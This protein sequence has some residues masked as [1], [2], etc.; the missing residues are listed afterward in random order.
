MKY[1]KSLLAFAMVALM[2]SS[3]LAAD[4][5][6]GE[7]TLITLKV[8]ESVDVTGPSKEDGRW[9]SISASSS[10]NASSYESD[11]ANALAIATPAFVPAQEDRTIMSKGSCNGATIRF[12]GVAVGTTKFYIYGAKD[13]GTTPTE[14]PDRPYGGQTTWSNS[15][16]NPKSFEITVTDPEQPST[17]EDVRLTPDGDAVVKTAPDS[18]AT[19]EWSMKLIP[20]DTTVV[21][22]QFDATTR[23]VTIAPLAVGSA[24]VRILKGTT[25]VID[26][27]VTVANPSAK[28]LI[29]SSVTPTGTDDQPIYSFTDT[30]ATGSL[31]IPA[32]YKATA[33]ILVIGGGAKGSDATSSRGASGGY[34]GQGSDNNNVALAANDYTITI[35][36]GQ[37]A[38]TIAGASTFTGGS[39]SYTGAAAASNRAGFNSTSDITGERVSYGQTGATGARNTSAQA[40][41]A[42]TG[43]GGQGGYGTSTY[44][45]GGNG[46]SGIVIVKILSFE[47]LPKPVVNNAIAGTLTY[48]Q[49]LSTIS[50]I[51][52]TMTNAQ[53][54]AVSGSFAWACDTTVK[55]TV[56]E[57]GVA[58]YDATFTPS[59]SDYWTPVNVK[60]AVTVNKKELTA[61]AKSF[62]VERGRSV[63]AEDYEVTY[64][65]WVNGES[66]ATAAGF[67]PATATSEYSPTTTYP[68]N[69]QLDIIV[70]G[71]EADN[72]AF[73]Y[74]NGK[75]TVL[76]PSK[77]DVQLTDVD[78]SSGVNGKNI[79]DAE[80]RPVV[81]LG[82]K[83]Y[84]FDANANN[85]E[86][87]LMSAGKYAVDESYQLEGGEISKFLLGEFAGSSFAEAFLPDGAWFTGG[88]FAISEDGTTVTFDGGTL[89]YNDDD[90]TVPFAGTIELV[91]DL[92]IYVEDELT[93]KFPA[94]VTFTG[95]GKIIKTGAGTLDFDSEVTDVSAEGYEGE[96][97]GEVHQPTVS[98]T[99]TPAA[100]VDPAR[101]AVVQYKQAGA[102]AWTA[103]APSFSEV[104]DTTV[105]YQ[106]LVAGIRKAYGTYAVKITQKTPETEPISIVM[107]ESQ[108]VS[109]Q[110]VSSDEEWTVK[111]TGADG[112]VT[113]DP[114]AYTGKLFQPT[115]TAGSAKGTATVTIES[116]NV[117]Y[118]YTVTVTASFDENKVNLAYAGEGLADEVTTYWWYYDSA[119]SVKPRHF[120][121]SL[122]GTGVSVDTTV[123]KAVEPYRATVITA[124]NASGTPTVTV[125]RASTLENGELGGTPQVSGTYPIS[126]TAKRVVYVNQ[127]K[128][129]YCWAVKETNWT[130]GEWTAVSA[131]E[132]TVAIGEDYEGGTA[133]DTM[134]PFVGK[135]AGQTYLTVSNVKTLTDMTYNWN[136]T[137]ATTE[138]KAVTKGEVKQGSSYKLW[139]E[140]RDTPKADGQI[141]GSDTIKVGEKL[142]TIDI[143]G[144][145]V[146]AAGEEVEGT[147]AWV[148]GETIVPEPT[149][150]QTFQATFTPDGDF[151]DEV[152]V[153]VTVMVIPSTKPT[154]TIYIEQGDY[155]EDVQTNGVSVTGELE[156][157]AEATAVTLT[158]EADL[159][160]LTIPVFKVV[161]GNVTNVTTKVAT[162]TIADGDTLEFFAEEAEWTDPTVTDDDIK[163]ALLESI[164][165]NDP[166]THEAAVKKVNDV[167]GT[168]ANQVSA[169]ALA[170]YI[171]DRNSQS[172]DIADCDYVAASVKLDTDNLITEETEVEI[173]ELVKAEGDG[174]T[175]E[176]YIEDDL[177]EVEAIKDMVEA[178][179]DLTDWVT[180]EHKLEVEAE[181]NKDTSMVKITP[182]D[183][184]DKAF[185]RVVIPKDPGVSSNA[186][187]KKGSGADG[188]SEVMSQIV[189]MAKRTT[190]VAAGKKV[191]EA[192]SVT[193]TDTDGSDIPLQKVVSLDAV[194][195]D[196]L[197][198]A[199]N[200][201]TE[202]YDCWKLSETKVW[203]AQSTV[204]VSGGVVTSGTPSADRTFALGEVIWLERQDATVPLHLYGGVDEDAE[205]PAINKGMNLLSA[206][207]FEAVDLDETYPAGTAVEG[208]E[209]TLPIPDK[210][211]KTFTFKN[212][213]WG[214]QG[215]I[216]VG[217]KGI[218]PGRVTATPDEKM[219][220]PAGHG[221]WYNRIA[222]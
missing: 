40:G 25:G 208:D 21:S 195:A 128:N 123:G 125:R 6:P 53:G 126:L 148:D 74:V 168:G 86:I 121:A 152:T 2:G 119:T 48:G 59:S 211:P 15:N 10:Y 124:A 193:W 54:Q 63:A 89:A 187:L 166:E 122:T 153:E 75:L 3:V 222:K 173:A 108:K 212:G 162:Y 47:A 199:W 92:T 17:S 66:A 219:L 192:V 73:S 29:T 13:D 55:P 151:Y 5:T 85:S 90:F 218:K 96:V 213:A 30:A 220:I 100:T 9:W 38:T 12:T 65:G 217:D 77:S 95:S 99:F 160:S 143:V 154:I 180:D 28:S 107:G 197:L 42:G 50:A 179:S 20:S 88:S 52:A 183:P 70:S 110:G 196:D 188:E 178:T 167:V 137:D 146:D 101:T 23:Q 62:S 84:T 116:T 209:V 26:Y 181:F 91:G 14:M 33:R 58:Q 46:G 203:E 105:D 130:A 27:K 185:M 78:K 32:N 204:K 215:F 56:A 150:T 177:V 163:T 205:L 45:A 221:F 34:G 69:T 112:L 111:I 87:A 202:I 164:D 64:S 16:L 97:D 175:F 155:V 118:V 49:A 214:Y 174:L 72:Y 120:Q 216:K 61:T 11:L 131:D 201:D 190:D 171:T 157:P 172:S 18:Q 206:P 31:K 186:L 19:G 114:M 68:D 83:T 79:D 7:N 37:T 102:S 67:E 149:G 57:S 156:L 159:D 145:M 170:T 161:R 135:K 136:S 98:Y 141:T 8:G 176:V 139:V 103:E 184:T 200:A 210:A 134:V 81:M 165:D 44:Q 144:T 71:G 24:T 35:G 191:R 76:K 133:N 104:V 127:V 22:A 117:K 60:L 41:D 194:K 113:V 129:A 80:G 43:N 1:M 39:V 207:N 82:G 140:V 36:A 4:V 158:L 182:K 138:E 169:R 109:C 93:V 189:A 94:D 51:G 142:N 147:F 106:I 115:I 198:Y 132:D